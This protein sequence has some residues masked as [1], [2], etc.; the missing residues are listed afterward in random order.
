MIQRLV[1]SVFCLSASV[2]MAANT[3]SVGSLKC[4]YLENPEGIDV[5]HP[6]LTW[7]LQSSI[8]G[9]RQTAY[10]VLVASSEEILDANKGDLWDSGKVLSGESVNIRYAGK[11]L[12]SLSPCFWK[13]RVW[14]QEKKASKWSKPAN[15]TMG[16]LNE[17]DWTGKW[18]GL[19]EEKAAVDFFADANWI[20]YPEGEPAVSAPVG[21]RVFTKVFTIPEGQTV[22][23]AICY[24]TA[25]NSG[26][27]FVN[28]KEAGVAR[29]FHAA[30]TSD[31]TELLHPGT[32]ELL[33]VA[34]NSGST[35][36]PAGVIIALRMGFMSGKS[37]AI[38]TDGHWNAAKPVSSKQDDYPVEKLDLVPAKVLGKS[39]MAPWGGVNFA[40]NGRRLPARWLRKEFS[41][42]GKV[43]RATVA[44]SG[45]GWSELYING[46]RVGNEVLSPALSDY[47]KRVFY[48][49][50]DVTE[51]L[52]NG[53]NAIGVVLGN[54][55]FYSPRLGEPA[56]TQTYG[57]PK[58]LLQLRLEYVNGQ[59]M[60]VVSDASWKLTTEG[61][62]QAN[63]EYDGEEYDATKDLGN[64]AEPGYNASLWGDATVVQAPGGELRAPMV[65]PICV[66]GELEPISVKQVKPDCWVYDFGQNFAGWCRLK[67]TGTRGQQI[68]LCHAERL[69][70]DGNLYLDNLRGAKVTDIFTLKGNDEEVFEPR[71]TLHG[72]RYVEIRGCKKAPDLQDITGM[73]V[74][75][76]LES[77]GHFECSN[78]ILN[79]IYSNILWGVRGNYRSIPTDCPQRD[80]RQGWLG[81][82]SAE[83]RGEAYLFQQTA[84]YAKWVQ[85][86]AD[87]QHP[88]GAVSD[89]CPSYW[90]FYGDSITWPGSMTIIPAAL[91][92]MAADTAIVEQV[93][94]AIVKWLDHQTQL[95]QNG[96]SVKDTYGDW[97]VPPED[98]K[99]IHSNDPARKTAGP[100]L[101]TTYLYHCLQLGSRYAT[102]LGKK[103][104]AQRFDA[105][106]ALLKKGLNA[107]FYKKDQGQYD[108]GSATSCIL[109]LA[110]DMVPT[111]ERSRVMEHLVNKIVKENNNH[112]CF[113]LVGG[114]WV[115]S[116]LS[117]YGQGELAY[118][119]ASQRTYP[120]LG[121]MAEKG[122]TTIWEL[123]NG[124]TADPAMNSG[125]HVMLVGD[126]VTWMFEH[127]AGIAPDSKA[128]GFHHIV[129]RPEPVRDLCYVRA[130]HV[131]PYGKITSDWLISLTEF[132]WNI[133]IPP[134]T[135]ASLYVP[136]KDIKSIHE[137]GRSIPRAKGLRFVRME[138]GRALFEVESGAY[139]FKV[140]R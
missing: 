26:K 44:Y 8:R 13:I 10:Q 14:D 62:I 49:T 121:Y 134:N 76:D 9:K 17:K 135:T 81:D 74:N 56:Q 140:S 36:N 40:D 109:P 131:S 54:G 93:Y 112:P 132:D 106:A 128:P 116:V 3:L 21:M 122:A 85:D 65:D 20:W 111:E 124:D 133:S 129:M 83:S 89:V 110:F 51:L 61:P 137:S 87:S 31:V 48:I 35:P 19:D 28:G 22:S 120:S 127:L 38:A 115:Y 67:V 97:C 118:V 82:R 84:L 30:R 25:D 96:I 15:W 77:A 113:G 104:D 92:D 5:L 64:W 94:P 1:W 80:E 29:D 73:V 55:R 42:E 117:Q 47:K 11:S 66:T 123:W 59:V 98:P 72:F 6:R 107:R 45:L 130:S 119:M 63:N 32:N 71:F 16:M 70:P 50:H 91:V 12:E 57:F 138:Q 18:I 68:R 2:A 37:L 95:I 75:D 114:Q 43:R 23:N 86:M 105:T 88:D 126:M 34:E 139:H 53:G 27:V 24:W 136:A 101:A 33:C 100:I 7:Q 52:K 39:G 103:E 4:E 79:R 125:N 60:N 69:L 99:L 102:M 58:L 90:Q 108:N 46:K 41:V 78:P